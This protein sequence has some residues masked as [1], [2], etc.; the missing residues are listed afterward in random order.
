GAQYRRALYGARMAG[1][2]LRGARAGTGFIIGTR[3]Q[4]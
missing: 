4:A 1:G 3:D 2:Q